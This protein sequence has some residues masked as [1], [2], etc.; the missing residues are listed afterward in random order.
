MNNTLLNK[1]DEQI[2]LSRKEIADLTIKFVNI[3]SV[4]DTPAPDAPFGLGVKKVLDTAIEIGK[5]EGFYT[6]DYK[7]GVMSA[8][9][10]EGE[11]DLGIWVHGDVVPEG[12][13]WSFEPYNAVEYEGRIVGRGAGD[14]K[15]Q[16]AAIFTLL[17]IFKKLGIELKYNPAIFVG[18]NE[19]TGKYDLIG[20]PDIPGAKG[21]LN[22][23]KAPKLSLVPDGAFPV[24]YGGK[25]HLALKIKS[26]R[27][28]EGMSLTA[29][30]PEAPGKATVIFADGDKLETFSPPVHSAHPDPNGNMITEISRKMLKKA[31]LPAYETK[32]FSFLEKISSDITGK[33]FGLDVESKTMTPLSLAAFK[34]ENSGG[35]PEIHTSIRFPVELTADDVCEKISAVCTNYG[36]EVSGVRVIHNPYLL[37]P[38]TEIVKTLCS[39]ANWVTGD[40]KTPYIL[41]GGTYAHELPNAY[42][43]GSSANFRPE[44][45]DKGRGGA[46]GIDEVVSLDRL[47]RA[48][49]IYARALLAL[50]EM[51]W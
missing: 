18:S 12:E 30:L 49:K 6:K 16:L 23:Y 44:S 1:I 36:F 15:G 48:M 5:N 27:P 8:A 50:N 21:F 46:H 24:G 20:N 51:N 9:L 33:T 4:Q 42:V 13:G 17:K 32:I 25:G 43:F 2:E 3:K 38:D 40:N 31:D 45:W 47:Q 34:I 28:L 14:N 41:S 22:L 39:V 7:I 19:E 10:K 35:C 11:P 37:D 26:T 29:G